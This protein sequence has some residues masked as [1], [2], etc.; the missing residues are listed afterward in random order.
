MIRPEVTQQQYCY[1][2]T[3]GRR[4]GD[5]HTIEI[6]FGLGPESSTLYMLAGSGEKADWVR[7]LRQKPA[8][9]IRLD[10][11][12]YSATARVVIDA[13]EDELARSMLVAKYQPG[14]NGD[15]TNWGQTALPVAF[16][17]ALEG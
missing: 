10:G 4:T 11:V 5:P 7:N 9:Q 1:L 3:R 13:A 16:D 6:W 17:L 12:T 14:Y 15:L 8:V 2:T